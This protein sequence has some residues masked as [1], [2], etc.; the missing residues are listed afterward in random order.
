MR[1]RFLPLVL[2][3]LGG[4]PACTAAIPP[5]TA[6]A[7]S[8]ASH[9]RDELHFG[10]RKPDGALVGEAEWQ[11]FVDSVVTPRFPDGL[12]VLAGYGQW[13]ARDG[14]LV[15]EPSRVLILV[16]Q[17][18]PVVE[19]RIRE[20]AAIYSRRFQQE[21]VMRV[22]SPASAEL[23]DAAADRNSEDTG[24]ASADQTGGR[25]TSVRSAPSPVSQSASTH[26]GLPAIKGWRAAEPLSVP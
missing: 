26:G 1:I 2:L 6:P 19:R 15:R 13:R 20:I 18:G 5:A 7:P 17:G 14:T 11:A 3:L 4:L 24:G 9:V 8:P 22:R 16:H 25:S 23:L 21:A 12:T 10:M